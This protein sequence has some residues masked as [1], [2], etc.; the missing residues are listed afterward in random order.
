D[1]REVPVAMFPQH[2]SRNGDPQLHVHV[3]WLNR[4]E[5]V[6]DGRW[7]AIDS[8]GLYRE[9][10][11]TSALAAFA[12]EAGL[13]RRFGFGW[14]SRPASKG[15]VIARFRRRRSRGSPRGGRRSPRPR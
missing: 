15:R 4:V 13:A 3:L 2:T 8:R 10:G 12:L 7:R 9:K 11:G 5:T 6:R 14:A 1:A